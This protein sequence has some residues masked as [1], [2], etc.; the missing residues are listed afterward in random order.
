[1][2]VVEQ[3]EEESLYTLPRFDIR[4]HLDDID[5]PTEVTVFTD[6]RT[7]EL[8]TQWVSIDAEHAV[9]LEDVR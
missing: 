7:V 4:C 9:A 1:M 2:S 3:R 8:A 6:T 5:D